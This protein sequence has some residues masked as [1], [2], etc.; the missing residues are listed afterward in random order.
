MNMAAA[1]TLLTLA[2]C[3]AAAAAAETAHDAAFA[4]GV[5][6]YE[7]GDYAAAAQQFQ[8]L[9]AEGVHEAA[10]FYNLAHAY[11]QQGRLGPAIAN[12]ERALQRNPHFTQAR[13]SLEQALAQT[14]RGLAPAE[15]PEWREAL[16]AAQ[17]RLDPDTP[18]WLAVG[19]WALFWGA[20]AVRIWR[21]RRYATTVAAAALVCALS[22]AAMAWARHQ[23]PQIAVASVESVPVRYGIDEVSG[24]RFELYEGDRVTVDGKEGDWIRVESAEG[25]RGWA[26]RTAFTLV[27]PPYTAAPET[28]EGMGAP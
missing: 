5:E 11:H 22:F 26:P 4:R 13:R 15:T 20:L 21:P 18:V 3:G 9:A 19:F 25:G 12:Y 23:P 17:S 14:E 6:A 2:L 7:A 8:Q 27:G 1:L 24:V 28:P 10:V 16:L